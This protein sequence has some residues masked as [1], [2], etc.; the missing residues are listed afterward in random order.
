M[1][2][3]QGSYHTP[4]FVAFP[5]PP[6]LSRSFLRRHRSPISFSHR[7]LAPTSL[8]MQGGLWS[9]QLTLTV[10]ATLRTPQGLPLLRLSETWCYSY[11]GIL[12]PVCG[13]NPRCPPQIEVVL[14]RPC[15]IDARRDQCN[16]AMSPL[17]SREEILFLGNPRSAA[18]SCG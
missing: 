4:T 13:S 10:S 16:E 8:T 1:G 6:R 15:C 9:T 17:L 18:Q 3:P 5:S 14:R 12:G 2:P 7:A 11:A